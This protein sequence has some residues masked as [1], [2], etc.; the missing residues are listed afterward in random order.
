M[1][2]PCSLL[3]PSSLPLPP[4]SPPPDLWKDRL[5]LFEAYCDPLGTTEAFIRNGAA[6]AFRSLG[7][8]ASRGEQEAWRYEVVVSADKRRVEMWLHFPRGVR[9]PAPFPA[10]Q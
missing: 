5:T 3:P 9:L 10:I 7:Y 6:H 2:Y 1:P 8:E 4:P